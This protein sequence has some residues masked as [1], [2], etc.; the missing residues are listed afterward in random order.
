MINI[1]LSLLRYCIPKDSITL[2]YIVIQSCFSILLVYNNINKNNKKSIAIIGISNIFAIIYILA[3]YTMSL[4]S[5]YPTFLFV[6]VFY[7]FIRFCNMLAIFRTD[8]K[9]YP[10]STIVMC[11]V[12]IIFDMVFVSLNFMRK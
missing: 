7:I 4:S 11:I 10:K 2:I 1:F 12:V 3:N 6:V 5:D 9:K 8:Y